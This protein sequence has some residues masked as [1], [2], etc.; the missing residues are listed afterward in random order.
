MVV[1]VDLGT[2]HDSVEEFEVAISVNYT[3]PSTFD[4]P[5]PYYCTASPLSLTCEV[6]GVSGEGV[7]YEW[8]STCVGNCFAARQTSKT[9]RTQ[10][11]HSYDSGVDTLIP[12]TAQ[13]MFQ[14]RLGPISH[15]ST[16]EVH[17]RL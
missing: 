12:F 5:A 6:E 10:Y 3:P 17:P 8:T 9:V 7:F 1:F 14:L 16:W 15:C 13:A 4:R 2:S 11:L